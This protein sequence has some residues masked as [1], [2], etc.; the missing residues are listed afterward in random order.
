MT[1]V[2]AQCV[3]KRKRDGTF[4]LN[5]SETPISSSLTEVGRYVTTGWQLTGEELSKVRSG[6][7][8]LIY[9]DSGE[10]RPARFETGASPYTAKVIFDGE[11]DVYSG[12]VEKHWLPK[13][14]V[15]NDKE[16]NGPSFL[17]WLEGKNYLL[18]QTG[19]KD[20][21]QL[22]VDRESIWSPA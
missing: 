8:V 17:D 7:P 5:G 16:M 13:M 20:R 22:R 1:Y 3:E 18:W 9:D 2:E 12:Q 6:D 10:S 4:L 19:I 15:V 14:I 21:F 11:N